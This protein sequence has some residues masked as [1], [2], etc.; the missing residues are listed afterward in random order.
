[1]RQMRNS[2][3]ILVEKCSREETTSEDLGIEGEENI[4]MDIKEIR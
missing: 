3:K 2:Y 4:T 1:M